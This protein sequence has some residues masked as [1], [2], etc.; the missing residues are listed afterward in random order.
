MEDE[1]DEGEGENTKNK[2]SKNNWPRVFCQ[3]LV[4]VFFFY[5]F[6]FPFLAFWA[7]SVLTCTFAAVARQLCIA[8]SFV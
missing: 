4:F 2:V 7:R 1:E 8:C 6:F 3:E 5:R